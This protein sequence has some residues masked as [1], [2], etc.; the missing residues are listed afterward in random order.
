MSQI[1]LSPAALV[2]FIRGLQEGGFIIPY[3]TY[4]APKP[5]YEYVQL[6]SAV[7]KS[8]NQL[9]AYTHDSYFNQRDHQQRVKDLIFQLYKF[10]K[11][12][13]I[14]SANARNGHA[15]YLLG[16][17]LWHNPKI[18]FGNK[19]YSIQALMVQEMPA[20]DYRFVTG[21][22]CYFW[23]AHLVPRDCDFLEA[24]W[25]E[26]Q[27]YPSI[28]TIYQ[29]W[30]KREHRIKLEKEALERERQIHAA[31][32]A[33]IE[34][35]FFTNEVLNMKDFVLA[36][37]AYFVREN[38]HLTNPN[39][40]FIAPRQLSYEASE[41]FRSFRWATMVLRCEDAYGSIMLSSL[42]EVLHNNAR[43]N[44]ADHQVLGF[45]L[46]HNMRHRCGQYTQSVFDNLMSNLRLANKEADW[47]LPAF[48]PNFRAH[49]N[50]PGKDE[51]TF[52]IQHEQTKEIMQHQA[53]LRQMQQRQ[54]AQAHYLSM[55]G[56]AQNMNA[57]NIGFTPAY[58][59]H[60]SSSVHEAASG[61]VALD[62]N[63]NQK[64]VTWAL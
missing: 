56:R 62:P 61:L 28:D 51:L 47:H 46:Y 10:A 25:R 3:F 44:L 43:K 36:L 39:T 13:H 53:Y 20:A 18:N 63:N 32:K 40:H 26:K 29:L 33:F 5:G 42:I 17:L 49:Q 57:A 38:I 14:H 22:G 4:E 24:S 54:Y 23:H 12:Y 37:Q 6:P 7:T 50:Y 52:I 34:R 16:L 58:Q 15:E 59:Q 31:R 60:Q 35:H 2:H 41:A 1:T 55:N 19:T 48:N 8:L 30:K 45:L 9:D 27:N 21:G 64:K 11:A